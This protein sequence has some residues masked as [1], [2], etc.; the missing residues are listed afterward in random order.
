MI[1]SYPDFSQ[2]G[3]EVTEDLQKVTGVICGVARG[4]R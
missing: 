3:T 4:G 2:T 1:L